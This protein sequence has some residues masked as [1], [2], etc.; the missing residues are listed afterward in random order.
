VYD[1]H[2]SVYM[3]LTYQCLLYSHINVYESMLFL[4]IPNLVFHKA[5]FARTEISRLGL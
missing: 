4:F 5:S 1:T 2:I 3:I